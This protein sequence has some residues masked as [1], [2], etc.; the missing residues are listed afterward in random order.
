M[1]VI[2]KTMEQKTRSVKSLFCLYLQ[3]TSIVCL[4]FCWLE[5]LTKK[6]SM[7]WT[8]TPASIWSADSRPG[9]GDHTKSL[10]TTERILRIVAAALKIKK[11]S[12]E[13]DKDMMPGQVSRG[14]IIWKF[15]LLDLQ[16]LVE[17]R[18]HC[19]R[20]FRKPH[21][22]LVV[23][24]VWRGH[25]WKPQCVWLSGKAICLYTMWGLYRLSLT[26]EFWKLEI[27]HG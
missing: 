2:S 21:Q 13:C 10:V 23:F 27:E 11:Y 25:C 3:R 17:K 24:D 15:K 4:H 8:L 18:R 5:K 16:I 26:T 20:T 12:N 7:N 1:Y 9:T 22:R 6:R 14:Q 19:F